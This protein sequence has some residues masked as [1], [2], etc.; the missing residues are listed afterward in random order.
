MGASTDKK[1]VIIERL[2]SGESQAGL[3]RE[4]G[5][6]RQYVSKL[7]KRFDD[8]GEALF[9]EKKQGRPKEQTISKKEEQQLHEL[10]TTSQP[11]DNGYDEP[12]WTI[13][14]VKI[15][16]KEKFNHPITRYQLRRFSAD[17][18]YLFE[19]DRLLRDMQFDEDF[20]KWEKSEIA[21]KIKQKEDELRMAAGQKTESPEKKSTS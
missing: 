15:W 3:A 9:V 21:Q 11:I 12:F 6:S 20:L 5:V 19:E 8:A 13:D 2:K 4:F 10:V 18:K 7:K 1:E 14:T 17:W 16:F